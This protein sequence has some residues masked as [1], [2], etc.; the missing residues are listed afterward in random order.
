MANICETCVTIRTSNYKKARQMKAYFEKLVNR[1]ELDSD[2]GWLGILLYDLGVEKDNIDKILTRGFVRDVDGYLSEVDNEITLYIEDAWCPHLDAI[3]IY[4]LHMGMEDIT[5]SYTAEEAGFG[6]FEHYGEDTCDY[7]LDIWVPEDEYFHA[8]QETMYVYDEEEA[9]EALAD[10][11]KFP[12]NSSEECAK[13][14]QEIIEQNPDKYS[15]D[16]WLSVHVF[17]TVHPQDITG[18][19]DED[20]KRFLQTEWVD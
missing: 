11:V 4:L 14:A 20:L 6:I 13:K 16:A 7:L 15:G 8:T 19:T 3:R 18:N 2:R 5:Y 12:F 10:V 1:S 9:M 17:T